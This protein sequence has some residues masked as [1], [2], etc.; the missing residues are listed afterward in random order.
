MIHFDASK[1]KQNFGELIDQA[2]LSPVAIDKYGREFV[3]VLSKEEYERL[4]AI[5]DIYWGEMA[6]SS[7]KEGVLSDEESNKFLNELQNA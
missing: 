4:S 1:A 6:M 5:E 3:I 7:G 2:R